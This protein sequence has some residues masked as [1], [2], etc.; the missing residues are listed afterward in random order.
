M[1]DGQ[2][3]LKPL[4]RHPAD[5]RRPWES[6]LYE[7]LDGEGGL[8]VGRQGKEGW[9]GDGRRGA[10]VSTPEPPSGGQKE[11]LGKSAI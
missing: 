6:L 9:R 8:A 4:R 1:E 5:K 10:G 11:A 7:K 2:Q 3:G